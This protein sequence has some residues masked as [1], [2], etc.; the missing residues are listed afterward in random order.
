MMKNSIS[1][2]NEHLHWKKVALHKRWMQRAK[3]KVRIV[4]LRFYRMVR[5]VSR[6]ISL[7]R[8]PLRR[9]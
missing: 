7:G 1:L 8:L 4:D 3:K 9:F 6:P 5:A 2:K